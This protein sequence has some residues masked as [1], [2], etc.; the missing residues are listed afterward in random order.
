MAIV[1][2]MQWDGV[3]REQYEAAR[4]L[5][6]WEGDPPPGGVLHVAAVTDQ[7]LRVTDVWESNEMLQSF[8]ANRLMPGV[9][10]VGIESNPRVEVFPMHAIFTP[11]VG[12]A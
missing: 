10:Q 3:T 9:R 11:G 8:V 7:G 12:T 2:F 1:M 5:V 6:N 4:K